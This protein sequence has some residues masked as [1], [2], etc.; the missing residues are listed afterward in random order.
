[1]KLPGPRT[2]R[3]IVMAVVAVVI[4]PFFVAIIIATRHDLLTT[5]AARLAARMAHLAVQVARL[6]AWR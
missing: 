4:A 2:L 6:M 5:R 3:P 1:M